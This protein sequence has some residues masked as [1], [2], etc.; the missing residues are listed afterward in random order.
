MTAGIR[1]LYNIYVSE[2]LD[3][4]LLREDDPFEVD[5]QRAHLFKH[6]HLGI[7]DVFDVWA[8]DPLFYPANC[9]IR[10]N[11]QPTG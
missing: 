4:D 10:R 11:H 1:L 6:R 8:G 2:R 7:A 9:S 3:P 5:T